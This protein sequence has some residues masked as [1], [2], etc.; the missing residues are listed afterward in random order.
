MVT[1]LGGSLVSALL[2]TPS[3]EAQCVLWRFLFWFVFV[4]ACVNMAQR[5]HFA[6]TEMILSYHLLHQL[7]F[8]THKL[9]LSRHCSVVCVVSGV[10]CV[11][12]LLC[13]LFAFVFVVF[14]FVS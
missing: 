6:C 7:I 8:F 12:F 1:W 4:W 10:V 3:E 2:P 13:G 5:C 9:E 14:C 11:V